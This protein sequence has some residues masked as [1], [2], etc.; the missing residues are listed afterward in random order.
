MKAHRSLICGLAL[1]GG[2]SGPPPPPAPEANLLLVTIAPVRA[3]RL[4][5]LGYPRNITPHLDLL[6]ADGAVFLEA[7]T[8][9]PE[10]GRAAAT[11]LT[12][13]DPARAATDRDAAGPARLVAPVTLAGRLRALG[14][15][16]L[17]ATDHPALGPATGFGRG[18]D[19]FV[20]HWRLPA[21]DRTAAVAARFTAG[22]PE[23]PF[24]VWLH[25]SADGEP[26]EAAVAAVR[27]PGPPAGPAGSA[28]KGDRRDAAIH[29][30]DRVIGQLLAS[31]REAAG[32]RTVIVVAGLH[33][34]S[35]GE[36]GDP[37]EQP[38]TL[39][40]EALRIPLIVGV[41]GDSGPDFP[42]GTRFSGLASL[43]DIPATALDLMGGAPDGSPVAGQ[44]GA[45][46]V[47]ALMGQEFRPHRRMHAMNAG[48]AAAILDGRLKLLRIPLPGSPDGRGAVL[49]LYALDRDPGETD[50]RYAFATRSVEPLR[51]ELETHRIQAV[52]WSREAAREAPGQPLPEDLL[53]AWRERR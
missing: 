9:W 26:D 36:R 22:V 19:A 11:V 50:N 29:A 41:V 21:A 44:I 40:D 13:L 42:R 28:G 43:A 4:G 6:A 53:A 33:G 34:E 39:F 1:A 38:R 8:P 46:L 32:G 35:L 47:P 3:D 18:F 51:A 20:E 12:G 37:A 16:T 7:R 5:I 31:L 52:A 45:S 25:F 10:T 24:F 2:C 17:A 49:A 48:G 23:P 15:R 14:Y 27:D 30:L